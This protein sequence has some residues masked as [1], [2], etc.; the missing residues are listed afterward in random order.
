[1]QVNLID[2]ILTFLV[3]WQL[4]LVEREIN[5]ILRGVA[6]KQEV[7]PSPAAR[8]YANA[9]PTGEEAAEDDQSGALKQRQISEGDVCPICQ[10]EFLAKH[11]PVTFCK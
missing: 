6:A 9:I 2:I 11:L 3:T 7:M 10:E 5:E 1:M 4:G 8:R